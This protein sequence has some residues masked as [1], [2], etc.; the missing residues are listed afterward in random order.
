MNSRE[1]KIYDEIIITYNDI[2]SGNKYLL[3]VI[4]RTKEQQ[5]RMWITYDPKHI[6][7][8]MRYKEYELTDYI[9][10]RRNLMNIPNYCQITW[11]K[12]DRS[13]IKKALIEY[14]SNNYKE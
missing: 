1:K 2:R 10:R 7:S 6:M 4:E 8:I 13:V 9:D 14:K 5:K 3:E 12:V 11:E